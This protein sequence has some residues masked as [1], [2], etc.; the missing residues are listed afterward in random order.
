MVTT[1]IIVRH[2]E[3]EWNKAG[4]YQGQLDSNLT[5]LG[6]IQAAQTAER[7]LTEQVKV[8]YTS[9]LGRTIATT[10]I[11]S[12]RL[13]L[14][15]Q[16]II[17]DKRLREIDV[18]GWSG[19]TD[20][21]VRSQYAEEFEHWQNDHNSARGGGETCFQ[22]QQR[23]IEALQMIASK[24]NG[25]VV[26]V[27]SHGGLIKLVTAAVLGLSVDKWSNL[28]GPNNCSLTFYDYTGG[29]FRLV[30]YNVPATG[31]L[32]HPIDDADDEVL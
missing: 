15:E 6:T 20:E 32:P 24:H 8:I 16:Q 13:G 11:I 1:I 17:K 28:R 27:V 23:G 4:I 29:H 14:T 26:V 19:L 25:E 30:N 18:G 22:V 12:R 31:V 2:G 3:T 7:L 9:D 21:Q 10:E 5:R